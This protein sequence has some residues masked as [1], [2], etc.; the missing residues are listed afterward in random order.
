[1]DITFDKSRDLIKEATAFKKTDIQKAISLIEQAIQICPETI[2]DDKFKLSGYYH[3]ADDAEKAYG[4]L[5]DLLNEMKESSTYTMYN[6]NKMQIYEKICTLCFTDKKF[7]DYIFYYSLQRFNTNLAIYTQ[8]RRADYERGN[9]TFDAFGTSYSTK[10][11]TCFKKINKESNIKTFSEKFADFFNSHKQDL[12]F[13]LEKSHSALWT[14]DLDMTK[15]ESVGERAN[16]ILK[17][18]KEFV[19]IVTKYTDEYFVTF[20]NKTLRPL[21]E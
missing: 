2:L 11:N 18:D 7:L 9:D 20:Y 16:R 5:F 10:I 13:I 14:K 19:R 21:L 12:M 6:M 1:M 8:G 3:L 4:I 17:A 15:M